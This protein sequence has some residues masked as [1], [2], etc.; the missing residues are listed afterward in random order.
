MLH[1][2]SCVQQTYTATPFWNSSNVLCPGSRYTLRFDG[3]QGAVAYS[4][5]PDAGADEDMPTLESAALSAAGAQLLRM[6]LDLD[7]PLV[8]RV[9]RDHSSTA[10]HWAPLTSCAGFATD[11]LCLPRATGVIAQRGLAGCRHTSSLG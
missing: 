1:L 3:D 5:Q 7:E 9:Q 6:G 2:V 10:P 4:Q 11:P 8:V